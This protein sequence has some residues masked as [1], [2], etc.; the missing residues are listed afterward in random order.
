MPKIS[1]NVGLTGGSVALLIFYGIHPGSFLR[2]I[3]R[4]CAVFRKV[5]LVRQGSDFAN[6]S[7]MTR[8]L[9]S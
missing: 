8:L 3:L 1:K 4:I 7:S 2:L 6:F 5:S 9:S